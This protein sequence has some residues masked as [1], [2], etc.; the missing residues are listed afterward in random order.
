MKVS[1]LRFCQ[2]HLVNKTL[3][4]ARLAFV[5]FFAYYLPRSFT[6]R[7]L[8]NPIYARIYMLLRLY[9]VLCRNNS[10]VYYTYRRDSFV[11]ML[12]NNLSRDCGGSGF[13]SLYHI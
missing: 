11:Q 5:N 3:S 1:Q 4:N 7:R 6:F 2:R 10:F 13:S 9:F 12:W 8:K